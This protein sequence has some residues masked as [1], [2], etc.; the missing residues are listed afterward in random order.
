MLNTL[1][2]KSYRWEGILPAMPIYGDNIDRQDEEGKTAL[3]HAISAG[4]VAMIEDLVNKHGADVYVKDKHG[5]T[6]I[7]LAEGLELP[8]R[9]ILEIFKACENMFTSRLSALLF[10]NGKSDPTKKHGPNNS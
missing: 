1:L 9:R 5:Q 6:P 7:A 2:D 3:H 10:S 8:H 4:N